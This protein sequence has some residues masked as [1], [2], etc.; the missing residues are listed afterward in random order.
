VNTHHIADKK[1]VR[2]TSSGRVFYPA[3]RNLTAPPG[4]ANQPL[5]AT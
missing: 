1:R 3:F 2:L 4:A 5:T